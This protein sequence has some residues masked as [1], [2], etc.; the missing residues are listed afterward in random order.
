[1]KIKMFTGV[2][3][4]VLT[5]SAAHSATFRYSAQNQWPGICVTGNTGRQSPINI[6]TDE[7]VEENDLTALRF[8]SEYTSPIEGEFENTCQNVEFTPQNTVNAFMRTLIGTY[9]FLQ[10]HFHWGRQSGEGTEHL[11]DGTA[12]EFEVHFV[13]K[14][15]FGMDPSAG[16]ALA[17]LAVRGKAVSR[18]IEDSEDIWEELD[19]SQISTVDADIDVENIIMTDLFPNNRDYY[20]YEG[21]LTTPDSDE[22]VQWFVYKNLIEVPR[23]YLDNLRKI[24]RDASGNLL[25]FNFRAPQELNNHPVLCFEEEDVSLK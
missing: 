25:T 5:F 10:F 12:E 13:H 21:S 24:E 17:V 23:A 8:S 20:Y 14:N 6:I 1:M 9:K 2:F 18:S 7:V 11:V 22:T 3:I 15:V 16:D 4:L 19:A